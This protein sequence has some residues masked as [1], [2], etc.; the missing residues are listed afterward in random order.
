[1]NPDFINQV[2]ELINVERTQA[3]LDS[4]HGLK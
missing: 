3:G 1:M 2:V 4:R